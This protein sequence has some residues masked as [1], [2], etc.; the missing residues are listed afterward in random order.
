MEFLGGVGS[1]IRWTTIHPM[2]LNYSTS[3]IFSPSVLGWVRQLTI[4]PRCFALLPRETPRL[5]AGR[6]SKSNSLT[7]ASTK[8]LLVLVLA[9]LTYNGNFIVSLVSLM[10][11]VVLNRLT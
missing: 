2:P 8:R 1:G 10:G 4:S 6:G 11:G 9:F 7:S 3:G 5:V